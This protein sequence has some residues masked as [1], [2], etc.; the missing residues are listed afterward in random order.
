[1]I[2]AIPYAYKKQSTYKTA[3]HIHG[4]MQNGAANIYVGVL[5]EY[6]GDAK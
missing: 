4:T 1:M 2:A 6:V 3:Y 5:K